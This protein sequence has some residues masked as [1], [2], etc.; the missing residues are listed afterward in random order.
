MGECACAVCWWCGWCGFAFSYGSVW[1]E[2]GR[3]DCY[4]AT[5]PSPS[6]DVLG[7]L[8][9]YSC[10]CPF[11]ILSA[12]TTLIFFRRDLHTVSHSTRRESLHMP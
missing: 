4:A 11:F 2:I 7:K 3:V 8:M 5:C 10:L 6:G 9:A 12:F 1:C